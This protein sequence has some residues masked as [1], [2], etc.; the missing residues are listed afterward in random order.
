MST[1][2]DAVTYTN[3]ISV[4]SL[5]FEAHVKTCEVTVNGKTEVL[6]LAA[7]LD[8]ESA[9]EEAGYQLV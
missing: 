8:F 1:M 3:N 7:A 6:S 2:N 9:L 4:V 5:A